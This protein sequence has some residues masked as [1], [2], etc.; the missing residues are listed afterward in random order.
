MIDQMK[1]LDQAS[2]KIKAV[3]KVLPQLINEDDSEALSILIQLIQEHLTIEKVHSTLPESQNAS[4]SPETFTSKFYIERIIDI[5]ESI[6]VHKNFIK[7][8]IADDT[9][10]F[11]DLLQ[12]MIT[13]SA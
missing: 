1:P 2:K 13:Q 9:P 10:Q 4:A 6:P 11:N 8:S 3:S 5:I 12:F 7:D